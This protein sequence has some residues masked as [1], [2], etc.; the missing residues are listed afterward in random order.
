MKALQC[1]HCGFVVEPVRENIYQKNDG[2]RK[3]EEN[4]H[5]SNNHVYDNFNVLAYSF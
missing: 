4:C 2:C 3:D 1:I 5:K